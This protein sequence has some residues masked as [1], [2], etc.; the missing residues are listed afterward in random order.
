MA[1]S[2]STS[3]SIARGRR[4]RSSSVTPPP[5]GGFLNGAAGEHRHPR[6]ARPRARRQHDAAAAR[7]AHVDARHDDRP[8]Q[9]TA[10]VSLGGAAPFN[11]SPGGNGNGFAMEGQPLAVLRG[12]YISQRRRHRR[13]DRRAEPPL[14]PVAADAHHRPDERRCASPRASSSRRAASIRAVN[15]LDEDAS[16][17]ALS[18]AVR[19][20]TC[21][22]A[23]G[24]QAADG[25][26]TQLDGARTRVVQ[27]V[28]GATG[29]CSSSRPI[30]QAA[31]R[32]AARPLPQRLV[33]GTRNATISL[34]VQN[35]FTWKN[36]DFRMFDPEM[37]GND[38]FN[39]HRPLHLGADPGA[40]DGA[41][42]ACRSS[43]E[44][45]TLRPMEHSTNMRYTDSL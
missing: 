25:D 14:R 33:P 36:K 3:P 8:E 44:T 42:R 37:A 4:T 27:L 43:S 22:D 19:W 28:A 20:P 40:G 6:Q 26:Q 30:S 24:K 32:D 35:W 31:R 1:A 7:Q 39:A 13:S 10:C 11:V 2:A 15:Y 16:Y 23:Y 12:R 41:W 5:S 18:R 38:G 17:Q 9:R 45:D 29:R 21:F 34:S